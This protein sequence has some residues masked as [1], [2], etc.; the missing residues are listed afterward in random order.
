L[1]CALD[2]S[3]R[4]IRQS[5]AA[6]IHRGMIAILMSAAEQIWVSIPEWER[7]WR[8]FRLGRAVAFGW[9]PVPSNIP[10]VEDAAAIADIRM[11][12]RP[13]RGSIIGHFGVH[14]RDFIPFWRSMLPLLLPPDSTDVLLL[15]GGGSMSLRDGLVLDR[16]DLAPRIQA[17]GSLDRRA[18][19]H[20]LAAADVLFQPYP[21]GVSARRGSIMAALA[22]G[23]PIVTSLGHLSE[24]IWS[25][26]AV[27]LTPAG[28]GAAAARAVRSLLDDSGE[29][30]RLA[31]AARELY[32]RRFSL[33]HVVRT[34]TGRPNTPVVVSAE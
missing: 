14:G 26:G 4:S 32:D 23:R 19:S 28:D 2:F 3:L 21:D 31:T 8:R 34:L 33:R 17:T 11:R 13:A 27:V 25:E 12:T 30:A 29:R 16:P 18:V 5:V 15:I 10:V 7:R 1:A 22:H 24:P 9:L 6:L 20:H